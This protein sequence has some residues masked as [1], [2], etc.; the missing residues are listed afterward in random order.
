MDIDSGLLILGMSF[1]VGML[2]SALF[3]VWFQYSDFLRE[4]FL[5]S[6][7]AVAGASIISIVALTM[8]FWVDDD[9]VGDISLGQYLLSLGCGL[10]IIPTL[11]I[12]IG[13]VVVCGVFIASFLGVYLSDITIIFYPGLPEW[14]NMFLTSLTLGLFACGFYCVAGLTP[15]PQSQGMVPAAGFVILTA[16]GLAPLV[17]GISAAVLLGVLIISYMRG[18]IQPMEHLSA[19][20]LGYIVGWLGLMSYPEYLLPCFVVFVMYYIMECLVAVFCKLTTLPQFA[21]LPYN[22]TLYRAFDE[23]GSQ[24]MVSRLIG[25]T[26]VL[27]L[28][29]GVFQTNSDNCFSFPIFAAMLCA[30]QQYRTANWQTPDKTLRE[31]N[32]EVLD[33]IKK[34]FNVLFGENDKHTDDKK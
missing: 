8:F 31:T 2:M 9:L 33:S 25:Y 14:L 15:F 19:M 16:L 7:F 5:S 32:R 34:S 24:E 30:W 11:F 20:L 29:L 3:H 18:M 22:S 27:L 13:A 23:S 26:G 4:N 28:I 10:L 17:M 1:V 21:E 6:S 12:P